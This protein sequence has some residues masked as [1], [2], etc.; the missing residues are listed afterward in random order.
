VLNLRV[1]GDECGGVGEPALVEREV[2]ACD[3]R[4]DGAILSLLADD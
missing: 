4:F 2:V 1:V 3:Q